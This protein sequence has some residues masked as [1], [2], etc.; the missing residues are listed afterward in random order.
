M[1]M[2]TNQS[3]HLFGNSYIITSSL[4]DFVQNVTFNYIVLMLTLKHGNIGNEVKC[5][6]QDR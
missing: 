6:Y 4:Y 5:V 2:L 3:C 1:L